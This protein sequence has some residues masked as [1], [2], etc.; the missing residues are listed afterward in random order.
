VSVAWNDERA[1]LFLRHIFDVAVASADPASAVRRNLPSKPVG[2]C[3]VVGAGKASAAMAAAVDAAWSDID[4]SG[5][6]VTRYG[7]S[8]PAGRIRILEAAHPVPDASSEVAAR[9][10]L[11]AVSGLSSKDLVL[12]LISGGGSS[13]MTLPAPGLTL[14]DKQ[15]VNRALLESGATIG[16]MNTVRKH[17]SGIK[18]G[19]LAEAA[20]PARLATLLISDVPGDD[21]AVIASGPT[22]PDP[23]T[24]ADVKEILSR[25]SLAIPAAALRCL[26]AGRETPKPGDQSG[27]VR[28]IAAP[29]H[30]LVAAARAAEAHG[31]T[32]LILGDAIE[33]EAQFVGT[34]MAGI[35]NSV[36]KHGRPVKPPVVL[37]SGGET[38][39]TIGS[40]GAGKGGRNTE[41]LLAFTIA[42]KGEAGIWALSGDSDGIDGS[43]DAAGAIVT[44]TTLARS[45]MHGLEA[46]HHL[47]A[48][49]S[50]SYFNAIGDLVRT[51]PTLTNVNDIRAVLV[52]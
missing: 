39:V 21:P 29:I 27:E 17:L 50:Y 23:S 26:A 10:T 18:G 44:P 11:D 7:H 28:I 36:R 12:A 45:R 24:H 16:E 22:V 31:V 8:V 48:H 14:A 30:S 37:L 41:F 52:A 34:V 1:R 40:G 47:A 49:D 9:A 20:R 35:A 46:R 42:I 3:V 32:P 5:V 43:D 33:G 13:L 25:Y 51:G 38:T 2:K 19:R 4:V 15:A 6:V